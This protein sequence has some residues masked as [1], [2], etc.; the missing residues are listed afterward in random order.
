MNRDGIHYIKF[1]G[2]KFIIFMELN[3]QLLRNK[4]K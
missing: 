3:F 4:E 1:R 2:E